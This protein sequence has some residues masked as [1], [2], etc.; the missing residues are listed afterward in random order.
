M[1]IIEERVAQPIT[2]AKGAHSSSD[3]EMCLLEAAAWIAGEPWSDH[4]AC[5]CPVIATFGR[6]WNDNLN[7]D[8][9]N[10]LL[11]PYVTKI[12]GTRSTPEVESIRSYM[13][14]DWL[15][16]TSTPAWLRRA[17]LDD[18]AMALESLPELTTEELCEAALPIINAAESAARSAAESAARSAAE[19]ATWSAARSAARSA[20]WS[21][22]RSAARS[23]AESAAESATRSAAWSA[24]SETAAE[25]QLSACELLDRMIEAK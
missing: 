2:L 21:A 19:S 20:A 22:A 15:V 24:L 4:P 25:L 16:R 5:V 10:R 18:H 17:G 14:A 11:A 9:R 1:T 23:A 13:A 6:T 7:D 3:G 12:V 8:D